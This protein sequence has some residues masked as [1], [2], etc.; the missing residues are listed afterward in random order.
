[1][2]RAPR[3]FSNKSALPKRDRS[4]YTLLELILAMGLAILVLV[5]IGMAINLYLVMLTQQQAN[6]ERQ[7]VARNILAMVSSDLRSAIQYKAADVSGL[8][9]LSASQSLIQGLL[10]SAGGDAASAMSGLAGGGTGTGGGTPTG[11]GV[12]TGG[13]TPSGGGQTGGATGGT[14]E[15]T[16]TEDTAAYRPLI[17]GSQNQLTIDVSRLP[18][19]DQYN[20]F[21]LGLMDPTSSR[22]SDVK[23][24]SYFLSSAP[25]VAASMEFDQQAVQQGGLYRRQIDRAVAS[26]RGEMRQW[27]KPLQSRSENTAPRPSPTH[28]PNPIRQS[29]E[30]P[31][32]Q[33]RGRAVSNIHPVHRGLRSRLDSWRP[34]GQSAG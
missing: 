14:T 7:Q 30:T 21:M 2:S 19:I 18:R 17:I 6:I 26:Y 23:S 22:P 12:P 31:V 1:M 3:Y 28:S 25:P 13:G 5:S 34:P 20:A 15:S 27:S 8:E 10:G 11:G 16:E 29:I 32:L 4:G 24:I 33:F 9:N